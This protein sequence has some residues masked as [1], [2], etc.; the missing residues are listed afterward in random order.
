MADNMNQI[1]LI[2]W[3]PKSRRVNGGGLVT[4]ANCGSA[5]LHT[6]VFRKVVSERRHDE[7]SVQLELGNR[8]REANG[9]IEREGRVEGRD[10]R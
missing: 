10:G 6:K 1:K 2:K 7:Q 8:T 3:Q 4:P 5:N 9:E